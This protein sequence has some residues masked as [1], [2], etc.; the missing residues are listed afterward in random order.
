MPAP[1]ER[2]LISMAREGS[3]EAFRLLVER[4]MKRAYDL[5]YSFVGTHEQAEDIS[6]EAFLRIFE[7]LKS[8]RGDSMFTTW[9]HR[10]V[11]NLSL[12]KLRKEKRSVALDAP[13]NRS[14]ME[15]CQEVDGKPEQ[16][17]ATAHLERALHE[18]PTLQRAV[19]ILR[20]LEGLSTRQ[21]SEILRCSEGTVKTHLFRGL[22]K[23]RKRLCYLETE[24]Q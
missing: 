24:Y 16:H 9:L 15:A 5:A 8:F 2:Q 23:L 20:H 11:V 12:D 3:H 19:V 14:V 10:I 18:L 4:H 22:R 6:Q 17:D 13:G 21:V 7:S 1:D